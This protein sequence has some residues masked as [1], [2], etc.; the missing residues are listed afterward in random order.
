MFAYPERAL[1]QRVLPKNKV[2]GHTQPSRALRQKFVDQMEEISWQY[3]L[4]PATI[5]LP[6]GA[7][8]KE[9][10]IFSI[11]QRTPELKEDILRTLD[12]A[13]PSLLFFELNFQG[14]V[15]FAAAYKRMSEADRSKQF[16]AAYYWTPWQEASTPRPALPVAI[17]MD[18]LYQ[19][20]LHRHMQAAGLEPRSGESL[21]ATA[22]RGIRIRS[23]RLACEKLEAR[24][25][26]EDQ[27]NRKVEINAELRK[28]KALLQGLLGKEP[29]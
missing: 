19:Q 23:Q 14:R 6:A 12:R 10:Q 17:N 15:R 11:A 13:I 24:L 28:A 25:R 1:Y 26:K 5:N 18:S 8:V 27:F 7:E 2:Y 22:E 3:K 21:E 4:S 20:M 29:A 16:V 9:I